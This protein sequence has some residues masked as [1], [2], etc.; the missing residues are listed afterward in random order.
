MT[1]Y[2][3]VNADD[4]G[5]SHG[6]N[7]GIILAHEEG[8]VTSASLMTR[9]AAAP[10][11][12][13]Y[14]CAHPD[15]SLGL[16][17]DL[18]EWAYQDGVWV[19]LYEVVSTADK[20][21]VTGEIAHQ[22]A[23]FRGLTGREPTHLDSHQHVHRHEPVRSILA[24]LAHELRVPLRHYTPLVRYCGDFYGQMD[25]MMPYREGI[26]VSRLV[27]ILATIPAGV[28]ELCCHPGHPGDLDSPYRSERYTEV[29][30]LCDSR[31]HTAIADEQIHLCA[32]GDLDRLTV[33][34]Q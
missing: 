21:A 7:E 1:R 12:A 11:A 32:F 3:I 28:T 4:F 30:T 18:G 25:K 8:I 17:V 9:G 5:L 31:V 23:D 34:L 20:D 13:E 2:L 19:P 10:E 16:H 22:L 29:R 6:I 27:E 33:E 26:G 24:A 14:G 15:F